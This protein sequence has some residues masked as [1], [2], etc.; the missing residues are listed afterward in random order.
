MHTVHIPH[1]FPHEEYEEIRTQMNRLDIT[2]T[3][4]HENTDS[5]FITTRDEKRVSWALRYLKDLESR[6]VHVFHDVDKKTMTT[7]TFKNYA[8]AYRG[9]DAHKSSSPSVFYPNQLAKIYNI[10]PS[11]IP[12]DSRRVAIIEL[13]GG[14]RPQDLTDYWKKIGLTLPYPTVNSVSINGATNNPGKSGDDSEVVLDIEVI[15]GVCPFAIMDVFFAP[16]TTSGFYN[17]ISTA[18]MKT[19]PNN[20][21]KPY[22]CCISIS[23]GAAE[24]YWSSSEKKSYDALFALAVSNNIAVFAA[25]GDNGSGDGAPGQN[26]DF[27]A[28]SPHVVACGGTNL[29]SPDG[30]TYG[31]ET[32]WSG[33]G[34]GYSKFFSR[35]DYQPSLSGSTNNGRRVPDICAVADPQTG[36]IICYG[37][38]CYV[39]G[40]TSMVAPLWAALYC[41]S[42]CPKGPYPAKLYSMPSASFHDVVKGSNGAYTAI[43]GYDLVTGLGSPAGL[44]S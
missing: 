36:A 26:V 16:N 11:S 15:G 37:G 22:Y 13:G 10:V 42:G 27:P 35:P 31:S 32:A 25:S 6:G 33:S 30:M 40:G 29:Q 14:Y 38:K 44:L 20:P 7:K 9:A 28:S 8:H 19:D 18:V 2:V 1:D 5:F 34:G 3:P 17:A 24:T 43:K 23:W 12:K 39:Y 21:S 41:N 4:C